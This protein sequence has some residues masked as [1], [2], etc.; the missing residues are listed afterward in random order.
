MTS[1]FYPTLRTHFVSFP[2]V[3]TSGQEWQVCGKL[4][5]PQGAEG[6]QAAVVIVHGSAGVDS[7][8]QM[9]ALDLNRAGLV[10]LEIDLWGARNLQG[11]S[12]GRPQQVWETLP[13]TF[14]AFQYLAA[15]P[16]VDAARIGLMGFSWGGCVTLLA[17]TQHYTSQY[18]SAGQKF[19]AHVAFYPVCWLYRRIPGYELRDLTGARVLLV[20]GGRDRYDDDV[21]AGPKL[22][23]SLPEA[24]QHLLTCR[25]FPEAEHGFNMLEAPYTYRDPFLYQGQGGEG[26]SA[27]HPEARET[28]RRELVNFFQ[29]L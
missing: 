24:D 27:P 20:T 13:D 28:V 5:L 7:R 15:L 11:G 1:D 3:D 2:V 10:T 25:V 21:Q 23:A 17:S 14:A 18:L 6:R 22:K 9:H 26:L 19:A 4:Q 16:E 12:E 29:T 8:G